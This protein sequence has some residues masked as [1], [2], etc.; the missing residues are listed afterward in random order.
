MRR[1]QTAFSSTGAALREQICIFLTKDT[2][3]YSE[4]LE[5][6]DIIRLEYYSYYFRLHDEGLQ[7]SR[8]SSTK[9]VGGD[10]VC[11]SRIVNLS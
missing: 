9:P 11:L 2:E 6:T 1:T 4:S 8:V 5:R 10:R 7:E 3:T